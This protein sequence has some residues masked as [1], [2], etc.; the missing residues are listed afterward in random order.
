MWNGYLFLSSGFG[1]VSTSVT[2]S[3]IEGVITSLIAGAQP[4][5]HYDGVGDTPVHGD[6][7][8]EQT[9]QIP[10]ATGTCIH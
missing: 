8:N 10:Q 4:S 5:I 7:G 9:I 2:A 1:K 6:I 3:N